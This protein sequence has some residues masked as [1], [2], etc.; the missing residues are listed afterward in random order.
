M[1][2]FFL[3]PRAHRRET[4]HALGSQALG[5]CECPTGDAEGK[6]NGLLTAYKRET[7]GA[8]GSQA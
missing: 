7:P 8:L 5:R 4:P 2:D 3:V 1:P 6:K